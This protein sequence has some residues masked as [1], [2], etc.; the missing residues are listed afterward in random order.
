MFD[1]S[2]I[3]TAFS[4]INGWRNSSDPQVP[5]ITDPALL[6]TDSGLYYNDFHPLID[7]E[8]IS[9][10]IPETKDLEDYLREKVAAGIVKV[11][12]KF[13]MFKKEMNSTKTILAS[14]AMFNGIARFNSTIV[15]ESRFVGI[16]VKLKDSLGVKLKIDRLGLQFTQVQTNLPIYVFHTSQEDYIQKLTVTTTKAGSMEWVSLP[17][18]INLN[19]YGDNDTGGFYYIGY[20]QD[21]ILGQALKKDFNWS[22]FCSGCAGR[23]AA[24]VWNTRLKFMEINPVYVANGDFTLM[25]M[26]DYQDA[27]DEFE[28]NYG[29]NVSTTVECDLSDYFVEQELV[30]SDAIGKQ[31]AVDILNDMKHSNRA[32]RIAEVNRNMIIRDLE[33]DKETFEEGLMMRLER[34]LMSLDF[35]FSKID[36]PCLPDNKKYGINVKSI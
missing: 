18:P 1:I 15:N 7:M 24:K 33:G 3:Q 19:Y 30:F 4:T 21:D 28:N 11:F 8:N 22:K 16:K 5:Q 9:N 23:S 32:N 12:N 20:Y 17:Q 29:I 35:D 36:S 26:F 27:V 25:K 13:S 10:T 2:T 34:S 14:T 31:V 6:S